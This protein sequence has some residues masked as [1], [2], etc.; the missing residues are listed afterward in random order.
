VYTCRRRRKE[1]VPIAFVAIKILTG[2]RSNYVGLIFAISVASMLMAHHAS[3]FANIMW[4]PT[5][6]IQGDVVS[7]GPGDSIGNGPD[8][9]P[10]GVTH[11][12]APQVPSR[13]SCATT[14]RGS[15]EQ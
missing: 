14:P 10:R 11:W 3:I 8:Q 2:D 6:Q 13:S 1:A 12:T 9:V 5:S 7:S 15:P 4:R